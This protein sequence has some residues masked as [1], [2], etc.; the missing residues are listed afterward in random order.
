[1]G[2]DISSVKSGQMDFEKG[3]ETSNVP[4]NPIYD[5]EP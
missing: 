1:M 4:P 3:S 5:V 2:S